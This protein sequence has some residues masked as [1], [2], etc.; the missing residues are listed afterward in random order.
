[1]SLVNQT[2]P[3]F[4]P[5]YVLYFMACSFLHFGTYSIAGGMASFLPDTLNRLSKA[6]TVESGDLRV[7]D[8]YQNF[9]EETI[10]S[11]ETEFVNQVNQKLLRPFE[12]SSHTFPL[13]NQVCDDSVDSGVYFDSAIVGAAIFVAFVILSLTIDKLGRR[14]VF[15]AC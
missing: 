12:I 2:L 10:G 13:F 6:R 1:M 9:Q 7:C 15:S 8:I 5:P 4:K 3:L 14:I 11:N